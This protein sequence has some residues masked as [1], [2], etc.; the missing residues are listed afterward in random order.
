MRPRLPPAP[1]VYDERDQNELRRVLS[2]FINVTADVQA[3]PNEV[4]APR[5]ASIKQSAGG[6]PATQTDV[7]LTIENGGGWGGTLSVWTNPSSVNDAD[8][9][10]SPDGTFAVSSCPAVVG[11]TTVFNLTGG[12]TGNLLNDIGVHPGRGKR[13]YALFEDVNGS[14]TGIWSF[15]LTSQSGPVDGTNTLL[16]G[17]VGTTQLVDAAVIQAKIADAAVNTAKFAAGIRPVRIV[18][19]LPGAG[20]VQGDTVFLTTDNKLYRWD[21]SAWT[22]S[23]DAADIA[24]QL[25]TSQLADLSITT[26]KIVDLA[27][28]TAKVNDGAIGTTKITD[29]AI[30]TPKVAAGVI[31][32]T[33]L[34]A[35]FKNFLTQ[36][37]SIN[38]VFNPGFESG[39]AFWE[40]GGNQSIITDS[41][42]AHSGNKYLQIVGDPAAY[43][44][45]QHL[46][47]DSNAIY[48][49]VSPGDTINWGGYLYREG[50]DQ[51]AVV[52]LALYDKDK[53]NPAFYGSWPTLTTGVWFNQNYQ[54]VVPAG[55]K[56]ARIYCQVNASGTTASTVRFDDIF[57]TIMVPGPAI[58]AS[59]ITAQQIA[60][61]TITGDRIAANTIAGSRLILSDF[62]NCAIDADCETG[63]G[64][65][66][67]VDGQGLS[68]ILHTSADWGG[69]PRPYFLE[70]QG[71][72]AGFTDFEHPQFIKVNPGEVYII[73]LYAAKTPT[74]NFDWGFGAHL[75]D[76]NKNH[77]SWDFETVPGTTPS[78]AFARFTRELNPIPAG[79]YYI[80]PW[81]SA[82]SDASHNTGTWLFTDFTVRRKMN[83]ELIVD[84]SVTAAKIAADTITGGQI[85]AGA[86]ST[87]ELAAHAITTDK[88]FIGSYDNLIPDPGFEQGDGVNWSNE[89]AAGSTLGVFTTNPR[90]GSWACKIISPNGGALVAGGTSSSASPH[91]ACAAG[92]QFYVEAWARKDTASSANR[93]VLTIQ[94]HDSTGADLGDF[95]TSLTTLTQ[96]YQKLSV[97]ATAPAGSSYVVFYVGVENA[98]FSNAIYVD[99]FYARRMATGDIIV[100]GTI[101]ATKLA[102]TQLSA[103]TANMGT[104][105]AGLIQDAS[106]SFIVDLNNLLLTIKDTQASPVTRVQIGKLGGGA[107]QY[108]L[109]VY[110][111]AAATIMDFTGQNRVL[112]IPVKDQGAK[113]ADFTID[114]STGLTQM[115]QLGASGLNLTL[116]NPVNGGRYRIWF[117]QDVTGS[118]SF[119]NITNAVMYTN[120][121]APTLTATPGAFDVYEFEYRSSPTPRFTCMPLQTN[122]LLPSP[123][124]ANGGTQ[125]VNPASTTHNAT[126]P[127]TVAAGDL[128][129]IVFQSD[130]SQG[131][132][133]PTTPGGWTSLAATVTGGGAGTGKLTVFAKV[134]AGTEGGTAVNVA[135]V[136]NCTAI[137]GVYRITQW[138]GSLTDL[139]VATAAGTSTTPDSPSVTVSWTDRTLWLSIY[140]TTTAPAFSSAPANY[141]NTQ[142][143]NFNSSLAISER[144][145]YATA[146][147][148]G[149]YTVGASADWGAVTIAIRPVA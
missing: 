143:N 28:T 72:G 11:P 66:P 38:A 98:G 32:T 26:A 88:L 122:V 114:L 132:I 39:S 145:L 73:S 121:A 85:A 33:K 44:V 30:T 68:I 112:A 108:G 70:T 83:A 90:S 56:Y 12:G 115:V 106:A 130:S 109:K 7:V 142:R 55:Y 31:T 148:P 139:V 52:V 51:S 105:T 13:I 120:G 17:S 15:V 22:K 146:E 62:T 144:R 134:A 95:G 58:V 116:S 80:R 129:L 84:G 5:F 63:R 87:S 35:G 14:S 118:R 75:Y 4:A 89:L 34:V 103:I 42:K 133:A 74:G 135:T 36:G 125:V 99:D 27:I 47:E 41:I 137:I 65:W 117:Q 128:L 20:D 124:T 40:M 131:T 147:N 48:W 113:S 50:G 10:A 77:V 71:S 2:D 18:T 3:D 119:P 141:S 8:A 149:N 19:S 107:D 78:T 61:A 104:L 45:S 16:A 86:I 25:T 54:Q 82:R 79:T 6:T 93:I 97:S 1:A 76:A 64:Q 94:F 57:F 102:V 46:D 43:I 126:M 67:T 91:P 140:G 100:D 37:S 92:D 24:G 96:T 49:E 69:C 53:A 136:A 127:A 81:I 111:A 138:H 110:D 29:N 101:T 23:T 21:G 123:I 60:A 59:S 9:T